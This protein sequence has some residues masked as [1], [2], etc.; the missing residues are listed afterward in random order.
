MFFNTRH[1]WDLHPSF[2]AELIWIWTGLF[3]WIRVVSFWEL[4]CYVF[5]S[6]WSCPLI[7]QS[8]KCHA[9]LH[10]WWHVCLEGIYVIRMH[11]YAACF[12]WW[13]TRFYEALFI[14]SGAVNRECGCQNISVL[15]VIGWCIHHYDAEGRFWAPPSG[16]VADCKQLKL[17]T[18]ILFP[19][20][21]I[22][23]EKFVCPYEPE[24]CVVWSLVHLVGLPLEKWSQAT[25]RTKNI[26]KDPMKK[27]FFSQRIGGSTPGP[28]SVHW[29]DPQI[30]PVAVTT[31]L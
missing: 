20:Q 19:R 1:W 10:V 27:R 12:S 22:V 15:G 25:G 18:D 6:R 14:H 3:I 5:Q 30:A 24:G 13:A 26:S 23:V 11:K 2:C 31:L 4:V 8:N 28:A 7:T 17:H 29:Q 21:L 16:E 9:V